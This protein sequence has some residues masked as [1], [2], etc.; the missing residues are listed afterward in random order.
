MTDDT[1]VEH[2]KGTPSE[3]EKKKALHGVNPVQ[4]GREVRSQICTPVKWSSPR[5]NMVYIPPRYDLPAL[6]GRQGRHARTK[7]AMA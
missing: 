5:R 3:I 6:W 1:P 7:R 4:L 2:P